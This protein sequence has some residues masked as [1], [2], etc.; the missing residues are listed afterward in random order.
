VVGYGYADAGNTVG[1]DVGDV[2][3]VGVL[4]D[5]LF[6]GALGDPGL[7]RNCCRANAEPVNDSDDGDNGDND[8]FIP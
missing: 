8:D 1:G 6:V 7:N 3:E 2:G 4:S 5:L